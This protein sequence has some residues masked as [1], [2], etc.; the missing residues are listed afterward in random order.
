MPE[1][2]E[3]VGGLMVATRRMVDMANDMLDFS[4]LNSGCY[5]F[6]FAE[7]DVCQV[8]EHL[9]DRVVYPDCKFGRFRI[10]LACTIGHY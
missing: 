7:H 2:A 1:Q 4:Q 3:I 6:N 5:E 8:F 10:D 9:A